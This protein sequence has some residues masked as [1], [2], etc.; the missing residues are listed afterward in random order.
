MAPAWDDVIVQPAVATEPRLVLTHHGVGRYIVCF[1]GV[2]ELVPWFLCTD[3]ALGDP[4][5]AVELGGQARELWPDQL[6]VGE[7]ALQAALQFF[8]DS[9]GMDPSMSWVAGS[10]F[11]REVV[12]EGKEQREA[13]ERSR[14]G[15]A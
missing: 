12:W 10:V 13:W 4:S 8:L 7:G 6:F 3:S 9:T 11:P 14:G 15:K 5:V 2:D 1:S